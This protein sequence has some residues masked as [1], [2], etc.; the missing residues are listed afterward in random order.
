M[1]SALSLF[2]SLP[3]EMRFLIFDQF[4]DLKNL[5]R[6]RRVSK[7]WHEEIT[8]IVYHKAVD[9]GFIQNLDYFTNFG[10]DWIWL[11]QTKLKVYSKGDYKKGPG[12]FAHYFNEVDTIERW[13]YEG[14]WDENLREGNKLKKFKP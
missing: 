9:L 12:T 4:S 7:V 10:C 1:S 2:E 14:D 11:L 5:I 13:W 6:L 3:Q 8:T